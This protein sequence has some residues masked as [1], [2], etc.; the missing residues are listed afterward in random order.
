MQNV[1]NEVDPYTLKQ[2]LENDDILLFDIR[3]QNEYAAG[4]I[5]GSRL[6]PLSNFDAE[7]FPED[8]NKKAVF[9]CGSSK[10]TGENAI[11]LLQTG[12]TDIY[13]L[14]GGLH[15]WGAVGLEIKTDS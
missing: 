14:G 7:D 5:A 1:I 4:Y 6:V 11:R 3:E 12:F 2:W 8:K 10:R 15:A 9:Y 13:H